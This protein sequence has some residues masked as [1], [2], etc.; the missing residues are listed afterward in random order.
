V[1]SKPIPADVFFLEHFGV[2][3]MQWGVRNDRT[4]GVSRKTDKEAAKDAKEFARAKMFYGQGAGNRRKLI[5]N[6]VAAKRKKDPAYGKAFDAHLAKQDMSTHASKAVSE[7]KRTDRKDTAKKSAG[8]VA[9]RFTGEMGTK[10]AFTAAAIAGVAFL[11]SPKGRSMMNS[12]TNKVQNFATSQ[13]A[14]KT[15][16][17]LTNY[18]AKNA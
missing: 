15:T 11:N 3:G 6:S 8:A 9:R 5:N 12:T 1:S 7:R 18:F 13:K 17:Y 16:D 4:G 2:K 14:K 10:A